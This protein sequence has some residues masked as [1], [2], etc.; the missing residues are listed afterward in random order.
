MRFNPSRKHPLHIETS[1]IHRIVLQESFGFVAE[2]LHAFH[3]NLR[4]YRTYHKR[5]EEGARYLDEIHP[6]HGFSIHPSP[7]SG[8]NLPVR[9]LLERCDDAIEAD[10]RGCQLSSLS[11]KFASS[12]TINSVGLSLP[13]HARCRLATKYLPD[14]LPR[15]GFYGKLGRRKTG[16]DSH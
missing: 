12:S 4:T 10:R 7:P 16:S 11:W 2:S 9:E 6:H 3:Y 13:Q 8:S 14:G 15:R 1:S 5:I